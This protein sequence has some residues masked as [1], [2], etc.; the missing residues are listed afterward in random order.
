MA[1]HTIGCFTDSTIFQKSLRNN[2][3][4]NR[5]RKE[6]G[7]KGPYLKYDILLVFLT[8]TIDTKCMYAPYP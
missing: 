8:I 1:Y 7:T 4:L 5:I 3:F 6:I 2:N